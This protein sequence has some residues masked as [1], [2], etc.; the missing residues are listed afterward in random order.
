MSRTVSLPMYDFAEVQ[1]ST[2]ALLESI[3]LGVRGLGDKVAVGIPDSSEHRPLMSYWLGTEMYLSQSCGLPYV[4]ELSNVVD[5]LGTFVWNGISDEWG[6]YRTHILVRGDHS[7]TMVGELRGARPVIS[8]PQ[9]LS[10]WCS[11]GCA[12]A[13]VTDDPDFVQPYLIGH[14]HAGSL[15]LLQDGIADVASIDPATYQLLRRHRPSLVHGLRNI[16][17]GP[18]IP[19]TPIIVSKTRTATMEDLRKLLH[20]IIG[21]ESLSTAMSEIGIVGVVNRDR[22]DYEIVHALV[23]SAERVL[24]RRE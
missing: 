19:A 20:R 12:L 5:V 11:L 8:N 7:A 24:P 17:S 14:H 2:T 4:E 3:V 16:G 18:L 1:D 9:S 13:E 21:T 10:G 22:S 6:N 15:Q 23:A